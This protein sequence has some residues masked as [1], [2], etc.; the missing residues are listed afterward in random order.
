MMTGG[1]LIG[2]LLA[3][4][5]DGAGKP[6]LV[7]EKIVLAAHGRV[8]QGGWV[9]QLRG[10][11]DLHLSPDGRRLLYLRCQQG[12]GKHQGR[13]LRLLML[14]DL[15]AGTDTPMLVPAAAD[16]HVYAYLFTSRLFDAAC[17]RIVLGAGVDA[18]NDAVASPGMTDPM[19]AVVYDVADDRMSYLEFQAPVVLPC[20]DRTGKTV[21]ALTCDRKRDP[22]KLWSADAERLRFRP[23]AFLG[24]PRAVCPSAD[25]IAML[26]SPPGA[27]A[28]A[29]KLRLYDTA[30]DRPSS[31]LPMDGPGWNLINTPPRWTSGGRYLYY[32]DNTLDPLAHFARVYD[33]E[34]GKSVARLADAIPIGPGPTPTTMVVGKRHSGGAVR[35]LLLHDAASGKLWPLAGRAS[36]PMAAAAGVVLY[37]AH[38]SRRGDVLFSARIAASGGAEDPGPESRPARGTAAEGEDAGGGP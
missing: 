33:R 10:P 24:L 4:P 16:A 23:L 7:D 28:F 27:K 12:E 21:Y 19:R 5:A 17:G 1:V 34:T 29:R 14:R 35:E 11:H 2:L 38:T 18:D 22:V 25:L 13:T 20:F 36:R 31:A 9:P 3:A 32:R 30:R 15:P 6:T 37:V 26:V 8:D